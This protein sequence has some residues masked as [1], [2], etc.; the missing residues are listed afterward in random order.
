MNQF[1]TK[2]MYE[3]QALDKYRY[4]LHI[5]ADFAFMADLD[6]DHFCMMA[7]TGRKFMW[8]TC[9]DIWVKECSHGRWEW[10]QQ[11]Q[12][13]RGLTVQ[14]PDIWNERLAQQVYVDYAGM[15]DLD[16]CGGVRRGRA[17]L[18]ESLVGSDQTYYLF[19]FALLESH[20]SVG[21]NGFDWGLAGTYGRRCHKYTVDLPFNSVTGNNEPIDCKHPLSLGEHGK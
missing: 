5:D 6:N 4:Y 11:Y 12:Q 21:E 1:F 9:Q 13:T 7:K 20:S 16:S 14:D 17:S 18:P 19:V 8:Q 10:F 15:V 2:V 3:Y